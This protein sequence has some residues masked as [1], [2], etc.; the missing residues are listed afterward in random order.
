M[1]K[2]SGIASFC[3]HNGTLTCQPLHYDTPNVR[4]SD[5]IVWT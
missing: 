3:A 2:S 4:V 5:C 1:E